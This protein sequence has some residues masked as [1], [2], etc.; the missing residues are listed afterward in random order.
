MNDLTIRP[1]RPDD[2]AR[3]A[4]AERAQGW[5]ASPEKYARRLSDAEAGLCVSLV[6]ELDGA[7]VGYVNLYHAA[8]HGPFADMGLPE[9]VDFGVLERCRRRGIGGMLMDAAEALAFLE[10]DIVTL[11]VGLHAGYGAAQ[12]MYVR[13]GYVPDGSGVWYM[14]EPL[15]PY[16]D[17]CVN[18]D[19]LV[20]Y[21]SKHK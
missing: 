9:I 6:A 17:A 20:L 13:R 7:P 18:D 12:R 3:I 8:R 1:L 4:E 11:G 19:D 16:S 14:D 15:A 5:N 21:L 10:S 2:C